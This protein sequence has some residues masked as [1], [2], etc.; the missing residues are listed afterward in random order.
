MS[1]R[2]AGRGARRRWR[3]AAARRARARAAARERPALRLVAF[4]AL[5]AVRRAALGDA[6]QPGADVAAARPA[7]AGVVARRGRRPCSQAGCA[8]SLALAGLVALLR[9]VPARRGAVR[10]V[11]HLRICGRPRTA[12]GQGLSALPRVA[13]A[14]QRASTSGSAMVILLGAGVLLLDAALM[15]AFAPRPLGDAAPRRGGAAAGRAGGRA[16]DARRAR[17]YPTCRPAAVRAAGGVHVGRAA[18]PATT[19]PRS[20]A[21]RRSPPRRRDGV[22]AGARHRTSRGST[23]RRCR[24]LAPGA[25]RAFDWS[26]RYGPLALAAQ[27]ATRCSRSRPRTPTTGR[28]RTSTCSTAAAG[29]RRTARRQP[30]R[31]RRSELDRGRWTQT[32]TV[33][34]RAMKTTN[35][36]A[37]GFAAR[38]RPHI[39][40]GVSPGRARD[41]DRRQ[42]S[43]APAT[44]TRS[45]STPRIPTAGQL[46][47]RR[48]SDYPRGTAA[49]LPGDRSCPA[50]RAG[51]A[52][53][54]SRS[55]RSAH[56][57][58]RRRSAAPPQRQPGALIERSPYAPRLRARAA[59]R[60]AGGDA[61]RTSS[62]AS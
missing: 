17:G 54:R 28:P 7:G 16:V 18:R 4:A 5:G 30:A 61:V 10:W 45:A 41:V 36:I 19:A 37:A 24:Q 57:R 14:L 38:S 25:R 13:R 27:R 34:L 23:T 12:I 55:R 46:A 40:S 42:R 60:A 3:R 35:V 58:G 62:R 48:R 47:E 31:R 59:P 8:R 33:T 39:P 15:L 1:A 44:A 49:R 11:R 22:R 29:C 6:A 51:S 26:Q 32:L 50:A 43:S 21:S 52:S 56:T 2:R 53:R 20:S 9:D